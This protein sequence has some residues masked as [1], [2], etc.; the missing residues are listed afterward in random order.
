M[1]LR[2]QDAIALD[3][4][5]TVRYRWS[6]QPRSVLPF[7]WWCRI[8]CFGLPFLLAT[9]Q[10]KYH[11]S[12]IDKNWG[13]F[14]WIKGS[15]FF[16]SDWKADAWR[17][18]SGKGLEWFSFVFV[19]LCYISALCDL[20]QLSLPTAVI[21]SI[22]FRMMLVPAV[23]VLLRVPATIH[24]IANLA[25]ITETEMMHSHGWQV[26]LFV[27][28]AATPAQVGGVLCMSLAVKWYHHMRCAALF[29]SVPP[30][31]L[32]CYAGLVGFRECLGLSGLSFAGQ[33]PSPVALRVY[34]RDGRRQWGWQCRWQGFS[35]VGG[36]WS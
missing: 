14:C 1:C 35:L 10:V 11:V 3:V 24:V 23:F 12:G 4:W 18:E 15:A 27:E 19:S 33:T 31:F 29:F 2:T 9:L 34:R 7:A 22:S 20:R 8:V 30:F 21:T 26:L 36:Q 32:S 17:I 28:E 16:G 13:E 25:K 6:Q 5:R